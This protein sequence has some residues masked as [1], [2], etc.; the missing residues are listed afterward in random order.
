MTS[1][2]N[3]DWLRFSF[4][5]RARIKRLGCAI[6]LV[7]GPLDR[8]GYERS[9][10]QGFLAIDFAVAAGTG[11]A[12]G[13]RVRKQMHAAGIAQRFDAP[14]VGN[15]VAELNDF[16][17]AAEVLDKTRRAAE[18]LAREVVDGDLAVIEIGVRDALQILEDEVLNDA[19]V[20]A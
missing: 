5:S 10:S 2:S 8:R 18:R 16:R 14:V 20:L 4:S 1:R 17:D 9:G 7:L 12:I 11:N 15:H 13:H 3:E 6:V 19:E